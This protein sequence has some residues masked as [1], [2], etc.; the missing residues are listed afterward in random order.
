[1]IHIPRSVL[2]R[3]CTLCRR[4]GL[5]RTQ[6]R[7]GS[8]VML[9]GGPEGYWLRAASPEV[10]IQYYDPDPCDAETLCLPLD[11]LAACDRGDDLVCV[12][13]LPDN[14]VCLSWTDHGLPRRH[15]ADQPKAAR[16][17]FPELPA[18]FVANEPELWTALREAVAVT[19]PESSRYA[20]GCLHLRGRLGRIEA[21]DGRQAL[22]QNG[23]RFAWE[24]DVLVP[25][26]DLLGCKLLDVGLPVRVGRAGSWIGLG[27]GNWLVMGAI[28]K[29]GRFPRLDDVFPKPETAQS[30]LELSVDDARFLSETLPRLPCPDDAHEPL[31]LD[32]NGQV[33]LRTCEAGQARPIQLELPASRPVGAPVT[34]HT[35]RRYLA[36][37]LRLGFQTLHCFG[38]NSPVLCA[39]AKRRFLWCLL[40][41]ESAI[42]KHADPIRIKTPNVS[43]VG[44]KRRR[45]VLNY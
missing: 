8:C 31:T 17:V 38:P 2:K 16:F 19:D 30:R 44:L 1:M 7:G 36:A 27:V 42:R 25:A 45:A 29:E 3:F 9:T 26:S 40:S 11:A 10:G 15:E 39:D 32:L 43:E 41:P 28:Q 34:L 12:E 6:T 18:D 23:F 4:G 33:L 5:H 35:D 37:A 21:T 13:G 24:E 22:A 14:R 20:L